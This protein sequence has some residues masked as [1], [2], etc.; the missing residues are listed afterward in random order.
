MGR[1]APD[2]WVAAVLLCSSSL[3]SSCAAGTVV[4]LSAAVPIT[5]TPTGAIPMEI[6]TRSSGVPS[7]L[8]L[9][10]GRVVFSA[11]EES[12][13]HAVATAT[14]P[15]ADAHRDRRPDGWQLLVDL[16][17]ARAERRGDTVAVTLGVRATLRSRVGNRYLAQTQAHCRQ[18]MT[19]DAA[20]ATP[21]FYAC[22]TNIGRELAGWLGGVEP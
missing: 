16:W 22:M 15:W 8:P 13:G 4:A 6:T 19:T 1:L 3:F 5:A 11:V 2:R 20:D 12:L 10:G 18:S 9:E 17:Q 7:P 14:V 21:V